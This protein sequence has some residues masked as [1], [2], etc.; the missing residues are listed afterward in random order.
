MK[1]GA[2]VLLVILAVIAIFVFSVFGSYNSLVSLDEDVNTQWANVE[3]KLQRRYDLI[4]NLVESVKGAMKQEKEVFTAIADARAKLAGAGTTSEK[5]EASNELEGALSRLLVVVENY[6]ELKS[7]QNV[8]ALMDEL[9]GT[10]NRISTE[11][12]RYNAVV[13]EYNRAIRSFPK[14]ILAG[15]FGFKERPY[16]EATAGA[17]VAPEVNF[18]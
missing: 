16:F 2:I 8:T 6:P 12:D 9:A 4:P 15:M 14:N 5:V 18:E 1:K 3:S 10:E 13:K 17:D 11:R 7:N